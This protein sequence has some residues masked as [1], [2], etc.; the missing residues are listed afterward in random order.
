MTDN[1]NRPIR[2]FVK[3]Q[4]RMTQGQSRALEELLPDFGVDQIS[5]LFDYDTIFQRQAPTVLE[6]GFGMGQSLVAQA[7]AHPEI[8]Y[9]GIEVHLP[10]VGSR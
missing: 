3:R 6:I 2:S 1:H 10:G 5:G 7:E 8:N 9:L 4:G